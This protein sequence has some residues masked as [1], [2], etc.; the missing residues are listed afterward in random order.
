[1]D[2]KDQKPINLNDW[3]EVLNVLS[4]F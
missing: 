4:I 1:M 2:N 3:L